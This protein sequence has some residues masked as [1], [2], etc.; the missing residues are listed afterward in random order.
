M[1]AT[2]ERPPA[3]VQTELLKVVKSRAY[4]I[5]TYC[6]IKA[7]DDSGD[8]LSSR[9]VPFRLWPAQRDVIAALSSGDHLII[10]KARQ[11]GQTWLILAC[12]LWQLLFRPACTALLF[13]KRETEAWAL[14][15]RLKEMF[16][17]LPPWL[18]STAGG[19]RQDNN[20]V[21][22]LGNGSEALAFPTTGGDS[23]TAHIALCDE[24]DLVDNQQELL[25]AVQPTVDAGGQMILLSRVRKEKPQTPFKRRYLAAKAGLGGWRAIFLPWRARP[26]R[27]DAWYAARVAEALADSGSLDPVHEQYPAS[28]AEALAPPTLN[29]RLPAAWLLQCYQA[30]T[31][32][33]APGR[34]ALPGLVVYA[35]PRPNVRYVIG[36]DPAEGNPQ[37]DASAAVVLDRRTRAEVARLTGL[38]EPTTF[39]RNLTTLRTWYNRASVLVERNNHGHAVI[40]GMGGA[41]LVRGPDGR[42]GWNTTAPSKAALYDTLADGLCAGDTRIASL[43]TFQQLS[44]IEANTLRAPDGEH[45][46]EAMAYALAYQACALPVASGGQSN[47]LEADPDAA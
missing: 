35:A 38:I 30:G 18:Q 10:L 43:S 5:D 46:D 42:Y 22:K 11:L 21:W 47:Y 33:Q 23:Y 25:N 4:F 3:A 8:G 13:S 31:P 2:V 40:A 16:A 44:S 1:I 17:H 32:T 24:F 19:V 7:Q 28:D 14:L 20:A 41:G 6:Q 36:A 12:I 26:D 15:T 9:W 37:S 29:K 39:A 34:P 45:D 27:T